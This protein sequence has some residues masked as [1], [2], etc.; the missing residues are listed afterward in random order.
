MLNAEA[1][2]TQN[3]A[4]DGFWVP[5]LEQ[6]K[7]APSSLDAGPT[8]GRSRERSRSE[9]TREICPSSPREFA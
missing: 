5:Q 8:T 7:P 1:H 4:P 6:I 2:S 3:F 9:L